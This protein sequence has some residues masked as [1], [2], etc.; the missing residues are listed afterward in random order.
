MVKVL[1]NANIVLEN[2]IIW[3]GVILIS[4]DRIL[5]T[6]K[7]SDIKIPEKYTHRRYLLIS[8]TQL[9]LTKMNLRP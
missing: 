2:G 3:D 6:G 8:M 1:V 5:E 7:A 9:S 4:D